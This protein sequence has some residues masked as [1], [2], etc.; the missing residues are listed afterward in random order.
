MIDIM[1]YTLPYVSGDVLSLKTLV[2]CIYRPRDTIQYNR[3]LYTI[4]SFNTTS[5][6]SLNLMRKHRFH[7]TLN[8]YSSQ[9]HSWIC[10]FLQ[11]R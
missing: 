4:Y 1:Y 5:N 7:G 6:Q 11:Q 2:L 8:L 3:Q 9:S 10:I